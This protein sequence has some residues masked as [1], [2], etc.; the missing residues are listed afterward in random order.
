MWNIECRTGTYTSDNEYV[1]TNPVGSLLKMCEKYPGK[2][3]T[4]NLEVRVRLSATD[5]VVEWDQPDL[6]HFYIADSREDYIAGLIW[7][8]LEDNSTDYLDMVGADEPEEYANIS[9]E[10][11]LKTLKSELANYVPVAD[12]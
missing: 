7:L 9:T 4:V 12:R 11:L 1:P 2:L 8:R 10:D 6:A 5:G 3:V